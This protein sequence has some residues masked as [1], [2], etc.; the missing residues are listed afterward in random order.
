MRFMKTRSFVAQLA[1]ACLL[2][3]RAWALPEPVEQPLPM[4]GTAGHGHTYPGATVPFGMVQLSPDTPIDGWD[5]CSGYHYSDSAI[6]GFSHTHL[7]GTGCGCLGDILVMPTVGSSTFDPKGY[8]SHF[9]HDREQAK[10]GVYRVFLD[11]PK[12]A[13]ELTATPR[14]GFHK[15]TFPATTDAHIILDLEHGVGNN[16]VETSLTVENETTVSGA[17]I[18]DGWGGRRAVYFVMELSKPFK[19]VVLERNGRVLDQTAS[20][21]KG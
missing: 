2:A 19:S 4:V 17:R 1:G 15:Y 13:V 8:R 9:S 5:G 11:D 7:S 18:S 16:A 3:A 12:V 14:C 6:V 10:P 20:T 21:G